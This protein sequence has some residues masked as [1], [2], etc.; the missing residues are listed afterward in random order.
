M[1]IFHIN[2]F[3]L[4]VQFKKV[5]LVFLQVH[6]LVKNLELRLVT[7]SFNLNSAAYDRLVNSS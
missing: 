5:Y 1:F 3:E 7:V 4:H 6:A 2:L